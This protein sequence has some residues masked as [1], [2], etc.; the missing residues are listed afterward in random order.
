MIGHL[1][2]EDGGIVDVGDGEIERIGQ[3]GPALID[4][5]HL[6]AQGAGVGIAGCTLKRPGQG[7]KR[8]PGG[9]RLPLQRLGGVPQEVP[10][11]GILIQ[12]GIG[13]KG[14]LKKLI[15]GGNLIRQ[16]VGQRGAM[17]GVGDG[18]GEGIV[19]RFPPLIGGL[20]GQR[21]GL[22]FGRCAAEGLTVG[23]K[24]QPGGQGTAIFQSGG[25]VEDIAGILIR[26]GACGQAQGQRL[27]RFDRL[28][29][30]GQSH[31]RGIV[32][33]GNPDIEGGERPGSF[34]IGG[35]HLQAKRAD[36]T[37]A[38]GP[39]EG[40]GGVVE[41]QPGG[42]ETPSRSTAD[43]QGHGIIGVGIQ[44]RIRWNL[45]AEPLILRGCLGGQRVGE[46][47]CLIDP[48]HGKVKAIGYRQRGAG[49]VG[50]GDNHG[51]QAHIA[52][53]G[54]TGKGAGGGIEGEPSRQ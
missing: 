26:E 10:P 15:L 53:L 35:A 32:D 17:V 2:E 38:G 9:Q 36:I 39:A 7:I 29:R 47:G 22:F 11:C 48:G 27:I 37:V 51:Q 4:G 21:H 6:D 33:V 1:P 16:R 45:K 19:G 25:K 49:I 14:H 28:I 18:D 12:K 46:A 43:G 13:G 40:V 8:Q 42:E 52:C 24:R 54:L 30:N 23:V 20:D 31:N 5:G 50:C 44:K 3:G 34:G 41:L